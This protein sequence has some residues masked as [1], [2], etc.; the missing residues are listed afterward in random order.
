MNDAMRE[1]IAKDPLRINAPYS[2]GE[3]PLHVALSNRLPALFDW[4]LDHGADPNGRDQKGKTTLHKAVLFDS[5]DHKALRALLKRGALVNSK[6]EHGETPLHLAAFLSRAAT[7]GALLEAG[8]DPDARNQLGETPLHGAATPQPTANP[9]N[10]VRTIHLLVA[11]GA[12]VAAHSSN[13]NTP[14][15]QAAL[16]GSVLATRT[17][18]TEGAPVDV[19]GLGGGT[20][21]HVAAMFAKADV[22]N[23]L[24]QAGADPN[25]RDDSGLTPLGRAL[26]YPALTSNAQRTGP[27][28]TSAV[29]EVLRRFGAIDQDAPPAVQDSVVSPEEFNQ[30]LGQAERYAGSST[31]EGSEAVAFLD[32]Y[33]RTP[34][35]YGHAYG[36]IERA[37][38]ALVL[39]RI[40]PDSE[41]AK[42][43]LAELMGF[44]RESDDS[45][46]DYLGIARGL[47]KL[48]PRARPLYPALLLDALTD[49]EAANRHIAINALSKV[50]P[51]R[52][53]LISNLK[54]IQ[55][56]NWEINALIARISSSDLELRSEIA[57]ACRD[58]YPSIRGRAILVISMI[59]GPDK[60]MLSELEKLKSDPEAHVRKK[61]V[62]TWE[63]LHEHL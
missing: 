51:T 33:L 18:L 27:V 11:G 14:L 26:H 41:T 48:G 49:H 21:V 54:R 62:E 29:V 37:R 4:L 22:A 57:T 52:Q 53:G 36:A 25:R 1:A 58:P 19:P 44:V 47:E 40:E 46:P 3:P 35:K 8:A 10:A 32:D 34:A 55:V 5:P 24:L 15:H 23:V 42:S 56:G 50:I 63:S 6:D 31:K 2:D 9:E 30:K 61:A 16:I 17:L 60:V 59:P 28:E 45:E 38:A 13:G 39:F 7:V 43:T 20:A 12:D